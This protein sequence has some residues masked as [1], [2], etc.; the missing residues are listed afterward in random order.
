MKKL[1]LILASF[2]ILPSA[3]VAAP[4][5]A[6]FNISKVMH[7]YDLSKTDVA[8]YTAA[9]EKLEEDPRKKAV[10][11]MATKLT[12]LAQKLQT[13]EQGSDEQAMLIQEA[14][15]T[16]T[17][18]N[19][20]GRNWSEYRGEKLRVITEDFVDSTNKRNANIMKIAQAMGESQGFDWVLETSGTTNSKMS[21]VLYVRDATDLTEQIIEAINKK[22]PVTEATGPADPE[23]PAPDSQ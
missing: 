14:E 8:V 11:E 6:T 2:F 21:V 23:A 1:L 19:D 17:A 4:K 18:Y 13:A 5:I 10:V 12:E 20:L 16:Q 9:K 15:E 3:S 7:D 22:E